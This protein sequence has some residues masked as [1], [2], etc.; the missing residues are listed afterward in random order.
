MRGAAVW[1]VIACAVGVAPTAGAGEYRGYGFMEGDRA[2]PS[3]PAWV[4]HAEERNRIERATFFAHEAPRSSWTDGGG[5]REYDPAYPL[6]GIS[7][8]SMT[9]VHATDPGPDNRV[10]SRLSKVLRDVSLTTT[11]VLIAGSVGAAVTLG[12]RDPAKGV[13][14]SAAL[15][16]VVRPALDRG[17]TRLGEAIGE[18]LA[19]RH[20]PTSR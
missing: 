15:A 13:A 18:A 9:D 19:T 8:S 4:I 12:T 20:Y 3:T 16:N 11:T 5:Y 2:S 1:I 6:R 7:V 17:T 14:T 10:S